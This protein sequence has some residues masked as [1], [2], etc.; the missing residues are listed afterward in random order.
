MFSSY[1]HLFPFNSLF[2][3]AS[4]LSII[5]I[6]IYNLLPNFILNYK[7]CVFYLQKKINLNT[8]KPRFNMRFLK[9]LDPEVVKQTEQYLPFKIHLIHFR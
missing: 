6:F 4:N 1:F 9:L 7:N 5:N 8:V 3:L 2:I